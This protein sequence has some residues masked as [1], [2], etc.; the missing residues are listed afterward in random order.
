MKQSNG[1]YKTFL[2]VGAICVNGFP[3]VRCV[4][5]SPNEKLICRTIPNKRGHDTGKYAISKHIG[6]TVCHLSKEELNKI[7]PDIIPYLKEP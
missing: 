6:R 1:T 4:I 3:P 5:I 2:T 7:C